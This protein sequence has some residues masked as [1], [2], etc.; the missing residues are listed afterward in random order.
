VIPFVVLC[1]VLRKL[2]YGH[3]VPQLAEA[4]GEI[5]IHVK[6]PPPT[7]PTRP[8]Q[9]NIDHD[10]LEAVTWHE[11]TSMTPTVAD[12]E[13]RDTDVVPPGELDVELAELLPSQRPRE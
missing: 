3:V 5:G 8:S 9:R 12:D 4:L 11:S 10:E 2:G 13:R 6:I 7:P 1:S